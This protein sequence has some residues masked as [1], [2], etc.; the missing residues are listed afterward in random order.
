MAIFNKKLKS[1]IFSL[2]ETQAEFAEDLGI[3]DTLLSKI[4]RGRRE[5][6]PELRQKIS[7]KLGVEEREVFEAEEQYVAH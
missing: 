6:T 1:A 4:I 2:Y 3:N 5:P 7:Q